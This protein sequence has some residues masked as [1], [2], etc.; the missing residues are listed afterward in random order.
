M[1]Q[2]GITGDVCKEI[3]IL[4]TLYKDKFDKIVFVNGGDRKKGNI[5]EYKLCKELG[6]EM[7]FNVGGEKIQ[8]SSE[9][10][11]RGKKK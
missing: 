7:K 8:S 11:K 9:L 4:H 1:N 3:K 10:V 6:I 5:P 2:I